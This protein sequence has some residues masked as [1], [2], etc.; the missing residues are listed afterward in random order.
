MSKTFVDQ[1]PPVTGRKY[2]IISNGDGTSSITDVTVYEQ[3]GTPWGASDANQSLRKEDY[4]TNDDGVVNDSDKLGGHGPDY[5]ARAPLRFT[6]TNVTTSDWNSD[7]TY[8]DYPYR[9]AV[10]LTGATATMIPDVVLAPAEATGGNIAPVAVSYA[11]G[12][13][14]YAKAIPDAAFTIP[15]ITLWQGV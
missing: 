4:D 9:K 8:T 6:D 7:A 10:A 14:L 12:I 11:G 3:E 13:Y 1:I 15:T 2:N 5:Y